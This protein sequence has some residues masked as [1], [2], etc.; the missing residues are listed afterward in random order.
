MRSP[1]IY[2]QLLRV[3]EKYI[4]ILKS[5]GISL[6]VDYETEKVLSNALEINYCETWKTTIPTLDNNQLIE[7]FKG[8]VVA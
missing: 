7:I 2:N 3:D 5:I 8:F 4:E 1:N 6:S